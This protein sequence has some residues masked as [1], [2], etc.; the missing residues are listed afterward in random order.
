MIINYDILADFSCIPERGGHRR[1]LTNGRE[2]EPE[3]KLLIEVIKIFI[4]YLSL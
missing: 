3:Q 1:K 4:V 2:G